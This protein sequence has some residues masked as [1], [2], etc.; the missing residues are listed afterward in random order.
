MPGRP[1]SSRQQGNGPQLRL[2]CI[3]AARVLPFFSCLQ[4]HPC[5]IL[6]FNRD[7]SHSRVTRAWLSHSCRS[8]A[9]KSMREACAAV[10][11]AG[12]DTRMVANSTRI[13]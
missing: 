2:A 7:G 11:A 9:L 12:R 5:Y 13:I 4:V 1:G 6:C 8:L 10:K 3:S